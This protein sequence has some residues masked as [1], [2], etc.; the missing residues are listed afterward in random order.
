MGFSNQDIFNWMQN[1]IVPSAATTGATSIDA[2]YEIVNA[3]SKLSP[4]KHLSIYAGSYIA[5]LRECMKNQF[6]ALNY[7]LGED[8]FRAFADE[9]LYV[10]P[11]ESYTLNDLGQHFQRYLKETR[12]DTS[13]DELNDWPD[14]IIELA[15]FE[16]HL[17]QLF[18]QHTDIE[19]N[20]APTDT[21]DAV[22]SVPPVFSIVE[23]TY[24]VSRYYL[25]VVSKNEP[26]IPQ[27]QTSYCA[28]VRISYRIGIFDLNAAQFHFL[29]LFTQLGDIEQ[30]IQQFAT[31]FNFP[32]EAVLEIWATWRTYFLKSGILIERRG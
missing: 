30:T 23:S 13:D 6:S 15:G 24:P 9:Y 27:A 29:M 32:I 16:Y 28:I 22:L 2:L 25:D 5:R 4:E 14:F 21:P 26:G 12:P 1:A 17:S 3:T 18:D 31:Q 20:I 19:A 10:Y 8:L 11:S 7:A